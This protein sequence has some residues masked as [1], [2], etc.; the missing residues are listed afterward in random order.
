MIRLKTGEVY[1]AER[2]RSGSS[3][4]G[5]W[6]LLVIKEGRDELTLW[7]T[8]TGTGL[9]D[10]GQFRIKSIDMVTKKN[11]PYKDGRL[12]RN[13]GERDVEW[14][15]EV[16]CNVTVEPISLGYSGLDITAVE[17]DDGGDLPFDMSD[18]PFEIDPLPL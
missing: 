14:R 6:E 12:C 10:G 11:A 5:P 15:P 7:V 17:F 13:R 1:T 9:M 3:G 8:N 16:D 4:N 2:A 18:I